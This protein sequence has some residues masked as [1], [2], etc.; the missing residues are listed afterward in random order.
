MGDE[1]GLDT[2]PA[3]VA[4][5]HHDGAVEEDPVQHQVVVALHH[6]VEEASRTVVDPELLQSGETGGPCPGWQ[7]ESRSEQVVG[8]R[9]DVQAVPVDALMDTDELRPVEHPPG[10]AELE[11]L[12]AGEGT[13]AEGVRDAVHASIGTDAT[14]V[15]APRRHSLW[16]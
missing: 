8:E 6:E 4:G 5:R 10:D 7:S 13:P 9:H 2:D 15:R 11:S 12:C 3:R 1:R 14:A 16:T